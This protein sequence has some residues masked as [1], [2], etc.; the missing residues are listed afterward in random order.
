V[1]ASQAAQSAFVTGVVAMLNASTQTTWGGR[2]LGWPWAQP[3]VNAPAATST[4]STRI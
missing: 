2:S 1:A 3:I 4:K